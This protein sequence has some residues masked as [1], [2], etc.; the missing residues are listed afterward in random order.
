MG[1]HLQSY[2]V[3]KAKTFCQALITRLEVEKQQQ[4][5]YPDENSALPQGEAAANYARRGIC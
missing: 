3:N 4:G 2:P 5:F 1:I